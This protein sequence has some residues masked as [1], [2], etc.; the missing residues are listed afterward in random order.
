MATLNR[1]SARTVQSAKTPGYLCDG[2]G[3]YLQVSRTGTKSWIFRYTREARTR[4]MGLGSVNTISLAEARVE[5]QELR[6]LLHRGDD[7]LEIRQKAREA[8]RATLRPVLDFKSCA[9]K[10]IASHEAGWRN[11]KHAAQWQ[12]TLT[13]YVYPMFG[14]VDVQD[15]DTALVMKALEPIWTAKTETA[16]RVRGRIEAVLDWAAVREFRR[17]ENPARWR[18]HLD[19]L[20]PKRSAVQQVEHHPALPYA[21]LPAFMAILLNQPGQVA[22]RGLALQIL[23]ACRTGE[24]IKAT[25]D[26]FDLSNRLWTIPAARMK[27]KREHRVPLSRQVVDLVQAAKL[28]AQSDYVLSGTKSGMALSNMAFLQLLKRMKRDNITSHGFRSTFRDWAAEQTAFPSEV[29]EMALAHIV[30][31]KVEAAYR[32]GDLLFKRQELMQ[33]WADYAFSSLAGETS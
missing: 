18:G 14:D 10:Y 17:G 15:I 9:E 7:P 8:K 26:E 11:A 2:G 5:A 27:A 1:L 30:S 28:E 16:S 32:R 21:D 13:T 12:S 33:A 4:D 22:V 3:L 19:H 24:I 23:T 29:V 31:N 6:K 20:L 25:F